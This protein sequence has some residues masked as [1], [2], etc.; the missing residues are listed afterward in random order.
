[1]NIPPAPVK[2]TD[3]S[4]GETHE[5]SFSLPS[6]LGRASNHTLN[7]WKTAW[8]N[9]QHATN[10]LTTQYSQDQDALIFI[11]PDIENAQDSINSN[12]RPG[13]FKTEATI[14][15]LKENYWQTKDSGVFLGSGNLQEQPHTKNHVGISLTLGETKSTS[16][17]QTSDFLKNT[18]STSSDSA[19][20]WSQKEK[21]PEAPVNALAANI[22]QQLSTDTTTNVSMPVTVNETELQNLLEKFC[23]T[24][25]LNP[26]A[27][28]SNLN[29]IVLD[30]GRSLPGTMIEIS[31]QGAFLNIKLYS[32]DLE[33]LRVMKRDKDKLSDGLSESTNLVVRVETVFRDQHNG[34]V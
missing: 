2:Q 17:N 10:Q 5:Q 24:L 16:E 27:G 11:K 26:K 6:N 3:N 34:S 9:K 15:Q 12:L 30:V 23:N 19:E 21:V 4:V 7:A 14:Q 32:S 28:L 22:Q 31:Q 33:T 20:K 18:D 1:M 8:D 29:N 13:Q 25:Y